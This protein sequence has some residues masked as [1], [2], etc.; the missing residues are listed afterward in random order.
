MINLKSL[1]RENPDAYGRMDAYRDWSEEGTITFMTGPKFVLYGSTDKDKVTHIVI[2]RAIQSFKVMIDDSSTESGKYIIHD[3]M[4]HE[5]LDSMMSH[6]EDDG[7]IDMFLKSWL[8]LNDVYVVGKL[9][10]DYFTHIDTSEADAESVRNLGVLNGRFF[11]RV[12]THPDVPFPYMEISFWDDDK[13]VKNYIETLKP[14]L[15]KLGYDDEESLSRIIVDL[16][17]THYKPYTEH[18][19]LGELFGV[20]KKEEKPLPKLS[21]EIKNILAQLK[22]EGH[23]V[24]GN[25]EEQQKLAQKVVQ[26]ARSADLDVK[27]A[28]QYV[29][30][31]EGDFGSRLQAK[32]ASKAGYDT[33]AQMNAA[34]PVREAVVSLK[35]LLREGTSGAVILS[36]PKKNPA[37]AR[38][39]DR[40][41][42]QYI[43]GQKG[44]GPKVYALTASGH[45][46]AEKSP[47]PSLLELARTGKFDIMHIMTLIAHKLEKELGVSTYDDQPSNIHLDPNSDMNDPVFHVIDAGG[48]SM[49]GGLSKVPVWAVK[50]EFNEILKSNRK[51]IGGGE[52]RYVYEVPAEILKYVYKK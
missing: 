26:V 23:G 16:Q 24:K 38:P 3:Y 43:L 40:A 4:K 20:S 5:M 21:D 47:Y 39:L 51:K 35:G 48:M 50:P 18:T 42:K 46:V 37:E 1:L 25:K 52:S 19:T 41:K 22:G 49:S 7:D 2:Y 31:D 34:R 36:A 30:N 33:V 17:Y 29:F 14:L 11:T 9:N 8:R 27:K 28:L 6:Y 15:E 10:Y 13:D 45:Y 32:K 44:L 12:R